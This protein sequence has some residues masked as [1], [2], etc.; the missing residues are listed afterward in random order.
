MPTQ[1]KKHKTLLG[2]IEA[3]LRLHSGSIE[4][5]WRLYG[6]SVQALFRLCSGSIEARLFLLL[7]HDIELLDP[8]SALLDVRLLPAKSS[9]EK[10]KRK[11]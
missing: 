9:R 8:F 10:R 6:G 5:L 2:S 1:N 4:A 11:R 3:L 7:Q